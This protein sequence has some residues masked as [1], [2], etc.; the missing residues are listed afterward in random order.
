MLF[1]E[2]GNDPE[3]RDRIRRR[4]GFCHQHSWLVLDARLGSAL[5]LAIVSRDLVQS[6]LPDISKIHKETNFL[7]K[8]KDRLQIS[9]WQDTIDKWLTPQEICMGCQQQNLIEERIIK[10]F[11]ES[12]ENEDFLA[13]L[14]KSDGVCRPHLHQLLVSRISPEAAQIL[15]NVTAAKWEQL[16]KELTEFIHKHDYRFSKEDIGSERDSYKRA[17]AT[18]VGNK[19]KTDYKN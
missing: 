1:Y 3:I 5:A 15:I 4:Q 10:T 17:I 16:S 11:I 6:F 13:N 7:A 19:Q 18:L 14:Q 12:L 2:S 9:T 8:I